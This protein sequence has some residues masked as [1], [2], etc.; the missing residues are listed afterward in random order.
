MSPV[1]ELVGEV[2][3]SR[4]SILRLCLLAYQLC[5]VE[6]LIHRRNQLLAVFFLGDL[7]MILNII[8]DARTRTFTTGI[9]ACCTLRLLFGFMDLSSELVGFDYY[10]GIKLR[11]R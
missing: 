7:G 2:L 9:V 4:G 1:L 8:F 5:T 11:Y 10:Q 6:D 3:Y